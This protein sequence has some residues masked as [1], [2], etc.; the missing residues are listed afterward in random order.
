MEMV[1][2]EEESG[3]SLEY[4]NIQDATVR[5]TASRRRSREESKVPAAAAEEE[6]AIKQENRTSGVKLYRLVAVSFGLLCILQA[7]LNVSLRLALYTEASCENLTEERDE[8]E[9]KLNT[10]VSLCNSLTEERD[11]WKR[12]LMTPGWVYFNGSFY[13]ISST[14]KTWQKSRNDCLQKGADLMIINSKDEQNFTR[15]FKKYLWIGL[16]DIKTEGR[17]KWVDGTW[18]TRSFWGSKEP[19]GNATENCAQTKYTKYENNWNDENCSNSHYWICEERVSP[20]LGGLDLFG[21]LLEGRLRVGRV[22]SSSKLVVFTSTMLLG[23]GGMMSVVW[24]DVEGAT[25][26]SKQFSSQENM[27]RGVHREE[28]E[29]IMEDEDLRVGSARTR[30]DE[31]IS[32]LPGR[33]L[34]RLIA[35]GFALLCIF[36]VV[37]TISLRIAF[38]ND[39]GFKNLTE[40]RDKLKRIN[41]DFEARYKN[42]TEERAE[43]KRINSAIETSFENL[44]EERDELKRINSD[45]EA[46]YKNVTE[47]RAELKRINS[48]IETSFENLTEER[49]ELKRI[50]SDFEARYKNVTEERAEL[51]RINSD[52]EASFKNLTEERDELKRIN[53]E[54]EVRFKNV[55]EERDE[56]E[57]KLNTSV[58]QYNSLVED[59]DK[60]KTKM[61]TP[62]WVYFSG[63]F[64]Y[65]SSV[66]KTWQESRND[67]LRKGADLIIINSREEQ[68][69]TRQ[70]KKYLWIGLTD[71]ETEGRWKWVD[72]TQ[73]TKSF[74]DSREPNG[75]R[76]ENCA[77][78]K[79]PESENNWNDESCSNSHYWICEEKVSP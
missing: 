74:W 67:C 73:L 42:L 9:R 44:T 63:K 17:W 55:A 46:R 72:G 39:T 79:F 5:K 75:K 33:K 21:L 70:F 64:Y 28:F 31:V 37:L 24:M 62:G 14:E 19:N 36:Q 10:S 49:D 61:T 66:M 7:A 40:E 30:C 57:R 16:T 38:S 18:L 47:E 50:N 23:S 65:V 12:R 25:V 22:I 29:F 51:K 3:M 59:R 78:T 4:E 52:I 6:E 43:L 77:Q 56:L 48:A 60:W 2:H 69:F 27:V 58:S 53:S 11:K 68:D 20:Q 41:S 8:L 32:A 45:F 34:C 13:Y 35:V 26:G 54:T 76:L 15:Q 71:I 1:I